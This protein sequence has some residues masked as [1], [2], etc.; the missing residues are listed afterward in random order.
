MTHRWAGPG[1]VR[2]EKRSL[3]IRLKAGRLHPVRGLYL[4]FISEVLLY[5]CVPKTCSTNIL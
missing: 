3:W 5:S 1:Y 2:E 4:S